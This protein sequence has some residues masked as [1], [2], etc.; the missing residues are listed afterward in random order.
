MWQE[1]EN[2]L[3][4]FTA[5]PTRWVSSAKQDMSAAAEWIWVVLQGDFADEQN[6]AQTITGTVISMIPF[7]DQLCDVRDVVA[8][9]RKINQDTSNKWAWVALVL[10]LIGLFPTLGSLAKRLFQNSVRLWPKECN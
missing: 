9:C 4:W 10:T 1:L 6:T 7:V 5:A 3:A 2:G 8:N